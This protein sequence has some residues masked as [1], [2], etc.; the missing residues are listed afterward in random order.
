MPERSEILRYENK[1]LI[2]EDVA[3]AIAEHIRPLCVLDPNADP[4][5]KGY[6]IHSLYFD[7][8]QLDFY[9]ANER[10]SLVRFKPR[11]RTYAS[12]PPCPYV[13]LELK[14][15]VGPKCRK[16][17]WRIDAAEWP[18]V[19]ERS[20]HLLAPELFQNDAFMHI[21]GRYGAT[22]MTHVRYHRE[23]YASEI[24]HYVRITFDRCITAHPAHGSP[25]L[26]EN[27]RQL[28]SQAVP[29]DDEVAF[30]ADLSAVLLEIKCEEQAPLWI[31]DLVQRF[32]LALRGVSKYSLAV[33]ALRRPIPRQSSVRAPIVLTP[34]GDHA[35]HSRLQLPS[36]SDSI[37]SNASAG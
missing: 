27:D 34:L 33:E 24:D 13:W 29:I 12:N 17:R 30:E 35:A 9:Y 5:S 25:H 6:V 10:K 14:C 16:T 11:A 7:T 18:Q 2:S 15:K 32:G 26:G 8:P 31:V 1:Y 23:A 36:A 3:R 21:I 28:L 4:V 37:G 20:P 22:P 19:L